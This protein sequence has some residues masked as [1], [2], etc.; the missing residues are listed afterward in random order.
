[1]YLAGVIGLQVESLQPV[2]RPLIP[3]NLLASLGLLLLFH[4]DWNRSF[5]LYCVTAF[6]VGFFVEVAGV[7][8]GL[9]FG[10]YQY[11]SALGWKVWEV[12]LVIGSNWLMLTYASG[13][14]CDRLSAPAWV[15]A[16]IAAALMVGL[17]ILI[18]PVAIELDFWSWNSATIPLQ[19]YVAWYV[20]SALLLLLF[21]RLSFSKDNRLAPLLFL[22]QFFFFGLSTLFIF[23]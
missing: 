12:P 8:T 16:L 4:T 1:M 15:K 17:D 23:W 6:L 10:S 11:G 13:S 2:F 20:V 21:Y 19:N 18:E 14:I 22:L 7:H 3:L 5:L 9:I